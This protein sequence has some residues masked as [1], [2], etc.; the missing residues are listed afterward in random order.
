MKNK[1]TKKSVDRALDSAMNSLERVGELRQND[2]WSDAVKEA[3]ARL[4]VLANRLPKNKRKLTDEPLRHLRSIEHDFNLLE[5]S[6]YEIEF[7]Q[8][9]NM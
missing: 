3:E 4:A 1:P 8:S 6:L 9:D 2:D 5:N 7:Y